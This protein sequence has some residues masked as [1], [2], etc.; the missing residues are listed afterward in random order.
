MNEK[1]NAYRIL[2]GTPEGKRQLGGPRCMWVDQGEIKRGDINRIDLAQDRNQWRTFV[3]TVMNLQVPKSDENVLSDCSTSVLSRWD[4][5]HKLVN[6][7]VFDY[8]LF[9]K[10]LGACEHM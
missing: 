10:V 2:L 6:I 8:D 4:K 5:L 7:Y 9:D 3:N 1:R